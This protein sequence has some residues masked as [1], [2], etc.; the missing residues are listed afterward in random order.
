[1]KKTFL[2]SIII[3][4]IILISCNKE[5][6]NK[7]ENTEQTA[8]TAQKVDIKSLTPDSL[9][10]EIGKL[11]AQGSGFIVNTFKDSPTI[12]ANIKNN[13]KAEREKI[14]ASFAPMIKQLRTLKA[15]D[16]EKS[17]MAA[18]QSMLANLKVNEKDLEA[19]DAKLDKL[20]SNVKDEKFHN[21]VI[22]LYGMVMFLQATPDD[23]D[24][25]YKKVAK[26]LGLE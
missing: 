22:G 25:N 9:G 15:E 4:S 14:Y 24:P 5:N 13:V 10:T 12:D 16:K 26:Y 23:E 7:P 21:D 1:M 6:A 20:I 18:M 3:L 19:I 8:L 11:I 17:I 2:L